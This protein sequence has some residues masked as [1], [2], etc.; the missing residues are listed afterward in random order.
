MIALAA[1]AAESDAHV[2]SSANE[3]VY[4]E[5]V[6]EHYVVDGG[7]PFSQVEHL[8]IDYREEVVSTFQNQRELVWNGIT[9]FSDGLIMS[10]TVSRTP[11][12]T[13]SMNIMLN[14]YRRTVTITETETGQE[15]YRF[16]GVCEIVDGP[17]V[18]VF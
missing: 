3:V 1:C 11:E 5:C 16:S 4:L 14:R 2:S 17:P 13:K 12:A 9:N 7:S 18:R 8:K 10:R 6:G 15:S